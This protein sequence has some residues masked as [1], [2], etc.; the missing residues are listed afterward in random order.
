MMLNLGLWRPITWTFVMAD[1]D[2][3]IIGA[4]LIDY[5]QHLPSIYNKCLIDGI[6]GI[7][8]KGVSKNLV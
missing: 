1:V 6:I 8:A 5:Y 3:P 4:G 2:T 7:K